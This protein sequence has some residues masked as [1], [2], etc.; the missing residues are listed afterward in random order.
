MAN[1]CRSMQEPLAV[2]DCVHWR[3][4]AIPV[5]NCDLNKIK[6][7]FKALLEDF[8]KMCN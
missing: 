5:N 8:S 4:D 6:L 2:K 1:L 3:K 7:F